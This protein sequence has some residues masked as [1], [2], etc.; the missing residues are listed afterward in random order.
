MLKVALYAV[1]TPEGYA[2][3][4]HAALQ[5]DDGTWSSKLGAGPLIHHRSAESLCGPTYGKIVMVYV[6]IK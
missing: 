4:T 6:K 2:K 1:A 5:H 3:F